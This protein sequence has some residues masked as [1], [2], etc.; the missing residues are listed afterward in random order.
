MSIIRKKKIRAEEA[1]QLPK[2]KKS[3]REYSIV[4]DDYTV[5][6]IEEIEKFLAISPEGELVYLNIPIA[7][8][9]E[10]VENNEILKTFEGR[11][12]STYY[13]NIRDL[14]ETLDAKV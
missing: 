8:R 14:F 2:T 6:L 13:K 5:L 3:W 10:L 12:P 7:Y 4:I 11:I 1:D 9:L